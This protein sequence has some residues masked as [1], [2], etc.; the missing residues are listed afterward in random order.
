VLTVPVLCVVLCCVRACVQG[1]NVVILE[2]RD[3]LGGRACAVEVATS[4]TAA[5]PSTA[6]P[7][8]RNPH[9]FSSNA[10]IAND[11]KLAAATSA[12]SP[13]AAPAPATAPAAA[14][15]SASASAAPAPAPAPVAAGE[16]HWMDLGG[17]WI[18]GYCAANPMK[19]LASRFGFRTTDG[20]ERGGSVI[21]DVPADGKAPAGTTAG[22]EVS[23]EDYS[24]GWKVARKC[25]FDVTGRQEAIERARKAAVAERNDAA[26]DQTLRKLLAKDGNAAASAS[27]PAAADAKASAGAGGGAAATASAAEEGD[28]NDELQRGGATRDVSQLDA[29]I[30]SYAKHVLDRAAIEAL[31]GPPPKAGTK[32]AKDASDRINEASAKV[33]AQY[34]ADGK[35]AADIYAALPDCLARRVLDW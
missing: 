10:K 12:P 33:L 17:Q 24:V 5:V 30:S 32:A 3:R 9:G 21:Y 4:T 25:H 14:S 23:F 7:D 1:L 28:L 20:G 18:H 26:R 15:A 19:L 31:P 6:P 8:P 35:S 22:A 2:A 16:K 29:F 13:A 27:A 34:K 11:I